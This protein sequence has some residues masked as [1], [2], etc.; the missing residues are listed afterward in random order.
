MKNMN[1]CLYCYKKLP[2]TETDFHNNCAKKIFNKSAPDI[3]YDEGEM[4]RLAKRNINKRIAVTG[5]QPKLSLDIIEDIEHTRLTITDLSGQYI[6]KPPF[7]EYPE[8]PE[9]E[10]L[11]M[12]L[13]ELVGINVVPH[14]L[15][16]LKSGNLGYLTK[17]IDRNNG[18]KIHM[19]DMCQLSGRL[20]EDKYKGSHEQI[21]KLIKQYAVNTGLSLTNYAEVVLF[22]FLTG[23]ADMHLKNFSL[24]DMPSVGYIYAPA[25]DLVPTKL[26][27]PEDNEELALTINGRK[28]KLTKKDFDYFFN[29]LGI[30]EKAIKNIYD[31]FFSAQKKWFKQID[32]SFIT[33]KLK[34]E[35]KKLIEARQLKLTQP[36]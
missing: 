5:V 1:N 17:R 8:L 36:H 28:S 25:Y 34:G 32:N 3:P 31:K 22:S 26:L 11:T 14:T 2:D 16:R 12:H 33:Q 24:I 18:S 4:Y 10:D 6:L 15:F 23:N 29:Y 27:I 20:T 30:N 13:A 21:G 7:E 9:L 35:Y 19:E